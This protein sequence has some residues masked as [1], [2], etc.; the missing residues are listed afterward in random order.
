MWPARLRRRHSPLQQ[1]DLP[2]WLCGV[3]PAT[4][5]PRGHVAVE[6]PEVIILLP[7]LNQRVSQAFVISQKSVVIRAANLPPRLHEA[8]RD[9]ASKP[10]GDA[11]HEQRHKTQGAGAKYLVCDE[12]VPV[13]AGHE[14]FLLL[15]SDNQLVLIL[16]YGRYAPSLPP[17]SPGLILSSAAF[18]TTNAC[19]ASSATSAT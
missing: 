8:L 12:I 1:P 18:A 14:Y 7:G 10:D 3:L 17:R 6:L 2:A 19:W 11:E 9:G 4:S 16:L 5:S 13:Q 15:T